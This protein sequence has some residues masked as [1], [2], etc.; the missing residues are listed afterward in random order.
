MIREVQALVIGGGPSGLAV[1]YSLQGDTLVLEK[2]SAVG[3]LCRSIHHDGAV[4]DIGGHSFHT[5]HPEVYD[6]VQDL[7]NGGL[8]QQQRDARVYSHNT[9][10]PYPFQRFFDRIPDPAVV[11]ECAEGLESASGD[12]A[13]ADNLEAYLLAKF[14]RGIARH[15]LLPY[16]RK[17]WARDIRQISCE[18][19]SERVAASKSE[20]E[21]FDHKSGQRK[22]LQP[23]TQVGYPREGGFEEIYRSFVPHI[24][25][26]ELNSPIARIDPRAR[27]A[28]G[29]D[30]RQYHWEFLVSTIPLPALVRMVEGTPSEIIALADQLEYMSL[31]VELLLAGR[32]LG[33]IQRIYVAD[34]D[35]PPHKIAFN[36]NS[37]PRLRAKPH[38][39]IMAEVSLSEDK[40]IDVNQI[41]PRTIAFLCDLGILDSPRDIV[42]QDHV[43]V[44][45]AYPVY[46]HHRPALVRGIKDW[47]ARH[48]IYTVGRFGD[49]EYV[50]SD[51]CVMRGLA[52]GR[53]LRQKYAVDGR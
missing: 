36:H 37:S 25:A 31:R 18:W 41:A 32:Q 24:P 42:W 43:D 6:L 5:P 44:K 16:N 29:P 51:R 53:S 49:W 14:G 8:Y 50:N 34:S 13:G 7:L 48:H 2:E 33:P 10:I 20:H 30:G 26:L 52:L 19:T 17:L 39:A 11:R 3:G 27:V 22:P 1:A 12:T 47:L 9:L 40:P 35:V 15:F 21:R 23:D 28:T 38:H 45:Y 4:F 46:T